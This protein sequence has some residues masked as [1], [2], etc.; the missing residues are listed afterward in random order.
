MFTGVITA[1][2][3]PFRN[4]ALDEEALRRLVDEQ[5]AAGVDGLVP[6]GTTG[7]S[8]TLDHAEHLRVIQIVIEQS[9]K[10][11]PVIAGTYP[12]GG[13]FT[14][15]TAAW[16]ARVAVVNSAP[17]RTFVINNTSPN[18]HPTP[19][20]VAGGGVTP[21]V[22]LRL[23]VSFARGDYATE[24]EVT[25][26]GTGGRQVTMTGFEGEYSFAYT[27]LAGELTR[28]RF[29]KT[30][31]ADTAYGWFV[32]ATQILSPRWFVAA[33][34]EGVQAPVTAAG[35]LAGTRPVMK[36]SEATVGF[37]LS[38]DFTLRGSFVGRKA[39]TRH[40]WDQQAAV[41]LVWAKRWW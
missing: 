14:A 38:T 12:L 37:R 19:A 35:A 18:P 24:D 20:I 16:D 23:G 5:I 10:R 28:D 36:Y 8:P 29:E 27:K 6:V 3:T 21:K 31:G 4:G 40:D 41:S 7:E 34:Q 9:R 25:V 15:S 33:R 2:V 22:G 13:Q 1:I 39:F 17:V 30:A 26:P 32:Q 11:V